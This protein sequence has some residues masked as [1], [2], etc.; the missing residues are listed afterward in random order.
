[1][2]NSGLYPIMKC[3]G[4]VIVDMYPC[5]LLTGANE[6]GNKKDYTD[7]CPI[8]TWDYDDTSAHTLALGGNACVTSQVNFLT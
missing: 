1:M 8:P 5:V 2:Y 3:T 4:G 6:C 7:Q